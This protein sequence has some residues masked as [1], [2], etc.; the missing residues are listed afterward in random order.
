MAITYCVHQREIGNKISVIPKH[1]IDY[2]RWKT[3]CQLQLNG[4]SYHQ[5]IKVLHYCPMI[6]ILK[7]KSNFFS[8]VYVTFGSTIKMTASFYSLHTAP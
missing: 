7:T 4:K 5:G 1:V 2:L 8:N 6:L 3:I